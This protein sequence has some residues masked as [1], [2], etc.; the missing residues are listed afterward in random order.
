V[1][2]T[3]NPI[4]PAYVTVDDRECLNCG[5]NG[6]LSYNSPNPKNSGGRGG[7]HGGRGGTR[8]G[9]WSRGGGRGGSSGRGRGSPSANLAS[10]EEAL[11]VTLTEQQLKMWEQW[12]KGKASETSL[13]SATVTPHVTKTVIKV[14]NK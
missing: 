8:G 9:R 12:Q 6:H 14:I 13:D 4:K 2:G 5:E 7:T 11:S 3:T 10:T 1:M